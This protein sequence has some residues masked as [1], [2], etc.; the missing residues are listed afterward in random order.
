MC[1]GVYFCI[2]PCHKQFHDW[3]I[4]LPPLLDQFEG[5]NDWKAKKIKKPQLSVEGL[6]LRLEQLSFLLNQPWLF[7]PSFKQLCETVDAL[8]EAFNTYLKQQSNAYSVNQASLTPARTISESMELVPVE[9]AA[10]AVLSMQIIRQH[11]PQSLCKIPF[12]QMILAQRI[13]TTEKNWFAGLKLVSQ[14]MVHRFMHGNYLSTLVFV[15]FYF[16]FSC[17]ISCQTAWYIKDSP[18]HHQLSPEEDS[19]LS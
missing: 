2:D 19:C 7:S 13:V 5:Y 16:H 6:N 11:F 9:V 14:S 18:H 12:L 17:I 10:N 8:A 15:W 1:K 3:S 4:S